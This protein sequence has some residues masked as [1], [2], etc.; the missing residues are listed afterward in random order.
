MDKKHTYRIRNW[1][2]YNRAL[3]KR[4]S[5]DVW[6]DEQA[7]SAW[8]NDKRTGKR[9]RPNIYSDEA[10]LCAL[11]LR[12]VYH[13]P[14]RALQGF[15]L[16]IFCTM[17]LNL[18]VPTYTR[19]C[20]RAIR[21]GQKLKRLTNKNPTDIVFDS[22]GIKVYG[23]GE[24]KVRQHGK[25]KRRVWKKV[26]LAICPDTHEIVLSQLTESI[27]SDST[28]AEG[29][30]KKLS[31]R[32]KRVYGDGAYDQSPF[33][34]RLNQL[35]IKP[36]IPPRKNARLQD[37]SVRPWMRSRNDAL[38]AITG[39]G[40][41]EDARKLWK[42]LSGYHRRSLVETAMSR[43]K[44]IFGPGFRSRE[45]SRQQAELYAKSLALNKMTRLGLPKR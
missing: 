2:E 42:A 44:G 17:C 28:T 31:R 36:L 41:N 22:T 23:E 4:G 32:T 21:L 43:F 24:W 20:R 29:M 40:G 13:L 5:L 19:I 16:W 33:Y 7:I 38:C 35:G 18:S 34:K 39:L 6:F 26:H 15:L 45:C 37:V 9:G 30:C 11:V 14:L 1:A 3:I 8:R 12:S 10:I 25:S 27:A